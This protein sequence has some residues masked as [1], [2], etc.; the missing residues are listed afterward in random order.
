MATTAASVDFRSVVRFVRGLES[1]LSDSLLAALEERFDEH[2]GELT[3]QDLR[4]CINATLERA[5][6]ASGNECAQPDYDT[7]SAS[8]DDIRN[9][10]CHDIQDLINELQGAGYGRSVAE[11]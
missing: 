5:K 9:G 8:L 2:G 3:L 6:E 4:E 11:N 7:L 10:R 1:R